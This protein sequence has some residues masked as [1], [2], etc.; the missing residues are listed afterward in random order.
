MLGISDMAQRWHYP[1]LYFF[2]RKGNTFSFLSTIYSGLFSQ[3]VRQVEPIAVRLIQMLSLD[4][5]ND[6]VTGSSAVAPV[7]EAAAQGLSLLIARCSDLELGIQSVI[8]RHLKTLLNIKSDLV[9]KK[10][11]N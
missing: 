8:F 10:L 6:F 7:R 1:K 5:F 3:F 9:S 4:R 11:H 2:V